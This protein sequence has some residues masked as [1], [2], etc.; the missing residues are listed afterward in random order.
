[1]AR[2]KRARRLQKEDEEAM[3]TVGFFAPEHTLADL[4]EFF[5][6]DAEFF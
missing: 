4:A 3:K 6:G 5:R 1:M 2:D